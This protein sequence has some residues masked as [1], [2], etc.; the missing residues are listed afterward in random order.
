MKG[1]TSMQNFILYLFKIRYI[2]LY[3]WSDSSTAKKRAEETVVGDVFGFVGIVR[4][5]PL[6]TRVV[7]LTV[8]IA[9]RARWVPCWEILTDFIGGVAVVVCSRNQQSLSRRH[10]KNQIWRTSGSWATT[11][12]TLSLISPSGFD[13]LFFFFNTNWLHAVRFLAFFA[14]VLLNCMVKVGCAA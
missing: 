5:K 7:R 2:G 6:R 10:S 11:Y 9:E 8:V 14:F 4:M 3:F 13:D 1:Y 12:R